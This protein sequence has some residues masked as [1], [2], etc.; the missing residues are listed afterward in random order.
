MRVWNQDQALTRYPNLPNRITPETRIQGAQTTRDSVIV[1][2][3]PRSYN[4]GKWY[5]EEEG[6][7]EPR[8]F[9]YAF[10]YPVSLIIPKLERSLIKRPPTN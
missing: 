10:D 3:Q 4:D 5:P 9:F 7:G 2:A 1:N 6:K 8:G